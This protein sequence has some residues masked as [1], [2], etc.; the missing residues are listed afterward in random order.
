VSLASVFRR[1]P[2]VIRI[3]GEHGE[4]ALERQ[5]IDVWC[6]W[7]IDESL[8]YMNEDNFHES[9]EISWGSYRVRPLWQSWR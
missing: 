6:R 4:D 3:S 8:L 9:Q 2:E 1:S 5:L 7:K